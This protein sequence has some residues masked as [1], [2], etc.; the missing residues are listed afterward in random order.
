MDF[1]KLFTDLRGDE[2]CRLKPYRDSR[3]VWTVGFG[4]NL[5]AHLS[6]IALRQFLASGQP[7][8]QQQ[9][10]A[11]LAQDVQAA[12][13]A[14]KS[15]VDNFDTLSDQRQRVLVEMAFN[16]G[17]HALAGFIN[18]LSSVEASDFEAAADQILH[19][20]AACELPT[21]YAHLAA[22]LRTG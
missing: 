4:H 17:A 1:D 16:L 15:L 2:G 7:I 12:C 11:M 3:G 19:S 9:A 22:M 6:P 21:R 5:E 13:E 20:R 8:T 10:D 18:T 14:V